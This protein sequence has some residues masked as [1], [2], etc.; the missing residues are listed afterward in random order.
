M[1]RQPQTVKQTEGEV[2]SEMTLGQ[3]DEHE[4]MS[5]SKAES[6][7]LPEN[8]A[9]D[10]R[11]YASNEELPTRPEDPPVVNPIYGRKPSADTPK[12]PLGKVEEEDKDKDKDKK[13]RKTSEARQLEQ[14]QFDSN[15]DRALKALHES[16][17]P[18]HD[19]HKLGDADDEDEDQGSQPR[20]H[21]A[22]VQRKS[23]GTSRFRHSYSTERLHVADGCR[24][25]S[26]DRPPSPKKDDEEPSSS[27]FKINL[28]NVKD[29]IMGEKTGND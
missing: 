6:Q 4:R 11:S 28:F 22:T 10:T 27:T 24:D 7:E 17:N 25:A 2:R 23:S 5:N 9:Q 8:A 16:K 26:L 14:A 12:L 18:Q 29:T 3:E 13:K 15:I 1:S 20:K 19:L 21:K